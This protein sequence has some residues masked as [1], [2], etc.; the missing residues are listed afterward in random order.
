M[1]ASAQLAV[2]VS[3]CGCGLISIDT[4][5]ARLA[6]C[7]NCRKTS[8]AT[9]ARSTYTPPTM[10]DLFVEAERQ[11][12]HLAQVAQRTRDLIAQSQRLLANQAAERDAAG[13]RTTA[14]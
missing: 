7:G 14:S 12:I 9:I 5:S 1:E 13:G 2:G 10:V 8:E 11:A 6:T 4:N 3:Q